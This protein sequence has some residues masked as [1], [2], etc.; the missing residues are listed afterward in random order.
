MGKM[1]LKIRV[2]GVTVLEVAPS[3]SGKSLCRE[4]RGQRMKAK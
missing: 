2:W 4:S 1:V 3:S